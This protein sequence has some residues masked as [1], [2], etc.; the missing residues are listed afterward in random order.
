MAVD[1]DLRSFVALRANNRCEY[2]LIRQGDDAVFRFPVDRII[3]GQH[4]GEYTQENTA[5]ACHHCNKKKG[6]NI[7][8][9]S[10][11]QPASVVR[12]FN[13]RTDVW[14]DHFECRGPVI[15]GVTPI[16]KATVE[17]LDMNAPG[18]L[19]LRSLTGYPKTEPKQ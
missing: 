1:E 8:S 9:V 12:L 4:G 7:A 16:G 2:C 3:S 17:L 19:R 5:L 11:N 14:T 10:S 13:P 6:P 18:K 15:V